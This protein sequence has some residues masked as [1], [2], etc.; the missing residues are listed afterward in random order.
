MKATEQVA[1]PSIVYVRNGNA[2][3]GDARFTLDM[4]GI[5]TYTTP[6]R[7]K[8]GQERTSEVAYVNIPSEAGPLRY[9]LRKNIYMPSVADDVSRLR[10]RLVCE[11]VTVGAVAPTVGEAPNGELAKIIMEALLKSKQLEPMAQHL[12][13]ASGY[14]LKRAR[15]VAH[16]MGCT[17]E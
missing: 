4:E 6:P 11:E 13:Q 14:S 8:K 5:S 1:G 9:T 3:Q 16:G 17:K 7:G 2:G 12:V 15:V 10:L